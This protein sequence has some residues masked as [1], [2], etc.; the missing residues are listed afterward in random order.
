MAKQFT[1]VTSMY[2]APMGRAEYGR[3]PLGKV[4]L[5]RVRIN[6]GGYD[7]G[8]AYWGVG[9]PLYCATDDG[10]YREFTRAWTR[11]E[12]ADKLKVTDRLRRGC[13]S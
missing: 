8:G 13:R 1:D 12:A 4:R 2:G 3:F 5:F 9:Q 11:E 6:S 10:N 7:D